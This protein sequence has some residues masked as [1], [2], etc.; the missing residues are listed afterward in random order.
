MYKN[1]RYPG[2][3]AV[4]GIWVL[5]VA[6]A[7]QAFADTTSVKMGVD[8]KM[9][10]QLL[11]PD[12]PGPYPAIL[13]LHTSGG[14]ESADTAFAERLVKENYVVLVP[15]FLRAYA[16]S[17][18]TREV[19]FTTYAQPIYNDFL[20]GIDLLKANPKVDAGKIAAIGFSNGGYFSLWLAANAQL[21]A[22]VA[23]YGALTGAATDKSLNR[24]RETFSSKSAPVLV[25][26]GTADGTVPF[27][28]AVELDSILTAV[29][30]PHEFYRYDGAGHRFE[31][32]RG[33]A[34]D[35][36]AADAWQRTLAFL[37][38]SLMK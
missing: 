14:L 7:S 20:T 15:A 16:I 33:E 37:K 10:A 5:C 29:Q 12:G 1:N 21:Q 38:K 31:R 36:A 18:K 17:G 32:D 25:M 19:S 8:Q 13:L 11:T 22:G 35:L 34:N 6:F 9:G 2:F 24:F 26:H 30:A 27:A 28:K 3:F 23:Y 4:V